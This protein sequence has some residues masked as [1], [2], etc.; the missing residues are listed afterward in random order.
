MDMVLYKYH[1]TVE[2]FYNDTNVISSILVSVKKMNNLLL[3]A[4]KNPVTV[5]K[6]KLVF[7]QKL[8]LL[9]SV[10]SMKINDYCFGF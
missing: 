1:T 9:L 2:C 6:N 4:H 5:D 8:N 3:Y 10:S 7:V